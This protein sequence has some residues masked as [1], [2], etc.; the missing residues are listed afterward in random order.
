MPVAELT[1]LETQSQ[2]LDP[3]IWSIDEKNTRPN[4]IFCK[5]ELTIYIFKNIR[6]NK[7]SYN[8]SECGK[9][10]IGM[11]HPFPSEEELAKLYSCGNYRTDAGKRFGF[12]IEFL[13]YLGRLRKRRRINQFIKTGKIL[14]IGCGRGLFL[15]VMRRGGWDTLGTE[16]NGETASYAM[17]TYGLK[18]FPGDI[19]RH[20]LPTESIDV[21][22]INQVLEHLKNPNK[23][24]QESYRLLKKGG[25]LII[26]VPNLRSPQ[27]AI[28]KKKWFLLDLPFHLFHFT[29]EGLCKLL[30]KNEFKVKYIKRFSLEISPFGWLQT[31]LNISGIRFNLLYDL[32]KSPELKDSAMEPIQVKGIIAIFLL[33]PIYFPLALVLSVLEPLIWKRGGSIEIYAEKK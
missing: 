21:I 18:I 11:L 31:L 28:G 22:N 4:C 19:A 33:L 10:K 6:I 5:Q 29:E 27:F 23:V 13:I 3:Q 9:C 24:I 32:L 7:N 17:K 16:F 30:S 1:P 2:L 14:D 25:M 12:A 15:D 8:L 20:K 26:S